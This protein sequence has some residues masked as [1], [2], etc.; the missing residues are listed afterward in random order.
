VSRFQ[1]SGLCM[2]VLAG[3]FAGGYAA[4]RITAVVHAQDTNA[5]RGSAFTLVD[6]GGNTRAMLRNGGSGG[7]LI[8][9]DE[10]GRQRVEITASGG[11][12]IRDRMGRVRWN[13]PR[14]GVVPATE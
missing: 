7:E 4:S 6:A 11:I 13:S 8:L 12:V 10:T 2:L 14:G 3:A 9:N 1:Y 5:I